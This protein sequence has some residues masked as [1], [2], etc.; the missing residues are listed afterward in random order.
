MV[1][2]STE[3]YTQ[4]VHVKALNTMCQYLH[5]LV[6]RKGVSANDSTTCCPQAPGYCSRVAPHLAVAAEVAAAAASL[7]LTCLI[8][9]SV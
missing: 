7:C 4:M 9:F 5:Q 8:T 6:K 1:K 3:Q 2:D